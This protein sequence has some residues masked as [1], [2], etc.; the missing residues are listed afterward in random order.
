MRTIPVI[1]QVARK[2]EAL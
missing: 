2:V 1:L